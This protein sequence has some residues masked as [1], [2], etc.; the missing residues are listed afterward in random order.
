MVNIV[1]MCYLRKRF[2][3]TA[4]LL[5]GLFQTMRLRM[6]GCVVELSR[7]FLGY[8]YF[9]LV[10]R[11]F[12]LTTTTFFDLSDFGI[13]GEWQWEFFGMTLTAIASLS[14]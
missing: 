9:K 7:L 2:D 5:R 11:A 1:C 3:E 6:R 13:V 10:C 12:T 8:G 4:S 14:S